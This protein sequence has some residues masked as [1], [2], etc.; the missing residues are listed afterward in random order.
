MSRTQAS[1]C[2]WF[3]T[4]V[5]PVPGS[6]ATIQRSSLSADRTAATACRPS[7]DTIGSVQR[8]S[9]YFGS[10]AGEGD[11]DGDGL[12]ATA[13]AD[14]APGAA[15]GT[16]V[17][18]GEGDGEGVGDGDGVG[19][20]DGFGEGA[21]PANAALAH[22]VFA[23]CRSITASRRRSWASPTLVRAGLLSA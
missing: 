7:R 18:E 20:G 2:S 1:S 21:G 5:S 11:G 6:T 3:R 17:G 10:A 14:S 15:G 9:R 12:A 4:R 8:T 22:T 19:E 16:G 13:G 23:V